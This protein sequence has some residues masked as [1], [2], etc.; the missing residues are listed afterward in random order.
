MQVE[1]TAGHIHRREQAGGATPDV[2]MGHP[3]GDAGHDR[4]DYGGPVDG[5]N[6]GLL[7]STARISAFSGRFR[8]RLQVADLVDE[9]RVRI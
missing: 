2:V 6:L 7:S 5:L 8:Y 9:L 3:C 1:P 4:Q